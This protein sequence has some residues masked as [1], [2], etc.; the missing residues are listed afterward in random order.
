MRLIN[1]FQALAVATG[2]IA[3]L[4]CSPAPSQ[5]P[6]STIEKPLQATPIVPTKP[7]TSANLLLGNPSNAIALVDTPDN[8]LMVK[9]QYALSYNNT[10]GTP[11]W[12]AW[13]LNKSCLGT[14][15]RQNNFRPDNTLPTNFLRVTPTIYSGSG[16][17]KGHVT[18]SAD[19]TYFDIDEFLV[20][21][22][23]PHLMFLYVEDYCIHSTLLPRTKGIFFEYNRVLQTMLPLVLD[24]F[25]PSFC[26][27]ISLQGQD[28]RISTLL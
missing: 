16:Y 24:F 23:L 28:Y 15:D 5:V 17:D 2:L 1:R 14:A 19:M 21:V 4:G 7:S 9:N 10:K 25:L 26:T 6:T 22:L 18:P 11:N 3:L 8:Y 20:V 27:I 12:V 13:Q